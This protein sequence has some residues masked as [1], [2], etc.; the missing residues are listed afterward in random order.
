[1]SHPV[2][3][4]I[5]I[6]E[7]KKM[8]EEQQRKQENRLSRWNESVQKVKDLQTKWQKENEKK[9]GPFFHPSN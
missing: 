3:Y 9:F 5:R 6:K 2:W 8:T 1:M 4:T 7:I